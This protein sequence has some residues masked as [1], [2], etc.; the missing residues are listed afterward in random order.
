MNNINLHRN[1]I[2]LLQLDGIGRKKIKAIFKHLQQ[3]ENLTLFEIIEAG[4]EFDL[5]PGT[6]G[7]D[8]L[9]KAGA[10]ADF[11]IEI[12]AK[13]HI[14]ML[15]CFDKS[16]P[17]ALVFE[18]SPIILYYQG[19]PKL[20]KNDH[21]VA[22]IGSRKPSSDG[23]K[24]AENTGEFLAE[25][26][27]VVISGLAT[28]C[29]AGG[30]RGC[31]KEGGKTLAF[32]PCGLLNIYPSENA[33]LAMKI[34]DNGGC[35]LSEYSHQE[36]IVPYKF[37]ERDRL[38]AASCNFL[39]VS[40]FS[41]KSGTIHTLNFAMKYHKKIFTTPIIFEQSMKGFAELRKRNIPYEIL[42][43]KTLHNLIKNYKNNK[44]FVFL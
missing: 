25:Q 16:Y 39:I 18:D 22:V 9:K 23:I 26:G 19:N 20:L 40:D 28:G 21:R 36:S 38:Q 24:F 15:S 13:N 14:K 44:S 4:K 17:D 33:G 8:A 29:D 2:A 34:L 12:N 35:L 11:I 41:P 30:H 27:F 7:M 31:L 42:E 43:E 5:I 10:M 6:M 32:L 37:I 3:P 1:L